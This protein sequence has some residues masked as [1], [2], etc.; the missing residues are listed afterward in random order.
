MNVGSEAINK[1]G[2]V[3]CIYMKE[4]WALWLVGFPHSDI[5]MV[6]RVQ[7]NFCVQYLDVKSW[8]F[9]AH[10]QQ[11]LFYLQALKTKQLNKQKD[12]YFYPSMF[13]YQASK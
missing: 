5:F 2:Q 7:N 12:K 6:L 4:L 1:A 9:I 8:L 10:I 11:M 3:F 13:L